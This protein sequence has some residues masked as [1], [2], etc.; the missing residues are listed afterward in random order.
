MTIFRVDNL[1][2]CRTAL[3]FVLLCKFF[4]ILIIFFI[5]EG[6]FCFYVE[7]TFGEGG[8]KLKKNKQHIYHIKIT[9]GYLDA[10][11]NPGSAGLN[12]DKDK[13]APEKSM[14]PV[15]PAY[16]IEKGENTSCGLVID[17]RS[18]E[19]YKDGRP[20]KLT[21]SEYRIFHKLYVNQGCFINAGE[22]YCSAVD[23]Q[24]AVGGE[25]K[26]HISNLRRKLGD[27]ARRPEYIECRRGFGYRLRAGVCREF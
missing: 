13:K 27:N 2:S 1:V 19:V 14:E 5:S 9:G 3:Y 22:L 26:W 20:L 24:A 7:H 25:V 8:L 6:I 11:I 21:P 12:G 4:V 18:F 17:T 23:D 15:A 10:Q 16:D